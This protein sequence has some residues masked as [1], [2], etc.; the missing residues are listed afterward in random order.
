MKDIAEQSGRITSGP[1]ARTIFS[2]AVPV[3]FGML[4]EFALSVTDFYWVGRLGPT[5][6]D[7]ITSAM[8]IQWTVYALL[9][10]ITVGITAI[11]AR[12]IGAGDI[13]RAR[14]FIR[15]AI[16]CASAFGVILSVCGY[17]LAPKLLLLMG[18][19]P[20]TLA[21]ATPY[22]QIFFL[23]AAVFGAMETI[24]AIFR[25][26]GDTRT[27]MQ[28]GVMNVV[29][30]MILD[31]VLIFGLGPIP[32][33][34][35]PGAAIAT[36]IS[37]T[38]GLTVIAVR[39]KRGGLGLAV[40]NA[41][42]VRLD[43]SAVRRITKIGLPM[44]SQQVTFVIVYWF[45]IAI[46]HQFGNKAGAAMGIGNRM[47][48]FSYLTCFGFSLA[49]STMVGQNL[50]AGKPDRAARGAWSAVGLAV[51]LT[52]GISVFFL[53]IPDL[54]AGIF[55]DDP[56][57]RDIASD[58]LVILGLSQITM[59]IEIVLEGAFGGAGDT[60]PPMLVMIPGAVVRIPLAYWLCFDLG[61][62]LN[63]VWW[64]LT[65]TTTIK[66]AILAWWF[67]R[68]RWKVKAI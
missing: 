60:V 11:V 7:A 61:L 12:H 58:Y 41:F 45:L 3:V 34:G 15:Q 14:Y 31:P 32:A 49:A 2:L 1:L 53:T 28:V 35:V 13:D 64:T 5:A 54:I 55:T 59:A 16:T 39:M 21:H 43:L 44:A 38:V 22:I 56:T 8:V 46:V 26:C 57:V 65:I 30:N 42:P 4:A 25:A 6:Q 51:L 36:A 66:A 10:L 19:S 47:E 67:H 50:G 48:A 20:Q 27:P 68:G 52:G 17:M 9:P 40:P 62:G 63:G 29:L 23:T 37:V 33:L 18:T 24:F